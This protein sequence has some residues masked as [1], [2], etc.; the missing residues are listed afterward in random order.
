MNF[1]SPESFRWVFSFSLWKRFVLL[2][3]SNSDIDDNCVLLRAW[4][5][6][7]QSDSRDSWVIQTT[8]LYYSLCLQMLKV[9]KYI[10]VKIS[11]RKLRTIFYERR[12]KSSL[13]PLLLL[14][15]SLD[16]DDVLVV[17]VDS[18]AINGSS[19]CF[20]FSS[21]CILPLTAK[22]ERLSLSLSLVYCTE[23]YRHLIEMCIL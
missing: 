22:R 5:G 13:L 18:T 17:L 15:L 9:E 8:F 19:R 4:C 20:F 10:V 2:E 6:Y 3:Y 12:R 21:T 7:C 1:V 16:E 14:L 11:D 23:V